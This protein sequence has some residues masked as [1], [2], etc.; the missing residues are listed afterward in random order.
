[1]QI[2]NIASELTWLQQFL[3]GIGFT[4]PTLIPLFCDNQ[5][6]IYIAS[7]TLLFHERTKHIEVDCQF[8][9]DKILVVESA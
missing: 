1:M 6:V 9:R 8:V 3:Q 7:I 4:A 2:S 5:V